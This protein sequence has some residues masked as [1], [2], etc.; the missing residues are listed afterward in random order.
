MKLFDIV[1][2]AFSEMRIGKKL[3]SLGLVTTA[4]MI[5]VAIILYNMSASVLP[6]FYSRY[7]RQY[8]RGMSVSLANA[9]YDDLDR[10]EEAG[11]RDVDI[12]ISSN[13]VDGFQALSSQDGQAIGNCRFSLVWCPRGDDPGK[14]CSYPADFQMNYTDNTSSGAWVS[15]AESQQAQFSPGSSIT[16]LDSEGNSAGVFTV[17][18]C[19]TEDDSSETVTQVYL[20]FAT[21]YTALEKDGIFLTHQLSGT[22]KALSA[23][24]AI[25]E[26]LREDGI[27]A[28]SDLD[29][30]MESLSNMQS[31]FTGMSLVITF[32]GVVSLISICGMFLKTRENFIILQKILGNTNRKLIGI[33]FLVME[34]L[35]I[36]AVGIAAITVLLANNYIYSVICRIFGDFQYQNL[37]T[38]TASLLAFAAANIAVLISIRVIAR[39]IGKTDVISAVSGRDS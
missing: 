22:V 36:L 29:L 8:P 32:A 34:I 2:Q 19:R 31:F 10:I 7:E 30:N 5:A 6:A 38:L 18:E 14:G 23:Y 26:S 33:Y 3:L 9:W 20:P 15:C 1:F 28:V 17:E 16:V 24:P 11:I 13:Y 27:T 21:V 4:A 12:L 25:K 39:K 35:L 37:N